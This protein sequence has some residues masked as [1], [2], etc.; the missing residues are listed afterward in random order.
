M[1][2][3]SSASVVYWGGARAEGG[4]G[5]LNRAYLR[6]RIIYIYTVTRCTRGGEPMQHRS[7]P[8][9]PSTKDALK[10]AGSRHVGRMVFGMCRQCD[11]LEFD[12]GRERE[13]E[14]RIR[15]EGTRSVFEARLPRPQY[16]GIRWDVSLSGTASRE[17][18]TP[19]WTGTDD[20]SIT[21]TVYM[22]KWSLI[23]IPKGKSNDGIDV[24]P[25]GLKDL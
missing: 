4:G 13:K 24:G 6:K 9:P 18:P 7:H 3:W 11:V 16:C 10:E 22:S 8:P 17:Q 2:R 23:L 25:D 15:T 21:A 5:V 14:K 1:D 12:I 20:A 19:F